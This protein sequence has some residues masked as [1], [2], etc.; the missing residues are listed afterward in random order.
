M[1]M[2][3]E[4]FASRLAHLREQKGLT[5]RELSISMGNGSNYIN[6]IET[7]KYFPKMENFLYMCYCLEITPSEF[8]DTDN[9][10]PAQL[11]KIIENLK[12]L[13]SKEIEQI[14]GLVASLAKK[15]RK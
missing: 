8:F 15:S 7:Q 14:E 5:A 11:N 4:A 12:C 9:K 6:D 2:E 3:K 1:T 10:Y 13:D